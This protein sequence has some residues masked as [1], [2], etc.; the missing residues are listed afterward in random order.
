MRKGVP[1]DR[2]ACIEIKA[3]RHTAAQ[4]FTARIGRDQARRDAERHLVGVVDAIPSRELVFRINGRE[5]N[6]LLPAVEYRYPALVPERNVDVVEPGLERL[7]KGRS[8]D[9]DR[10]LEHHAA[11]GGED[12]QVRVG[13]P[14]PRVRS[15]IRVK[16]STSWAYVAAAV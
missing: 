5:I 11:V 2:R 7:H 10:P 13:R 12:R 9:R 1:A 16:F 3:L 15:G 4:A 14:C 8:A 6:L